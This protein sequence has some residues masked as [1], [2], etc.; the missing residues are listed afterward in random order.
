M[1]HS[2]LENYYRT[3]FGFVNDLKYSLH[4]VENLMIYERDIF[5]GFLAEKAKK[6][7]A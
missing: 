1:S 4:E 2:T 3:L 7:Q 5:V 6:E